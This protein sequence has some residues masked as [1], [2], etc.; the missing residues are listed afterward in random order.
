MKKR[1]HKDVTVEKKVTYK[2]P[3]MLDT[4][5]TSI[6]L[7]DSLIFCK[8]HNKALSSLFNQSPLAVKTTENI[9]I[10]L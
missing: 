5:S 3:H 6:C 8:L 9:K 2:H 10:K 4:N 7:L 1:T